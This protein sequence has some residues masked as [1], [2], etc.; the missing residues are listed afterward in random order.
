MENQE[1]K[2]F[3]FFFWFRAGRACA[4]WGQRESLPP[5]LEMGKC[6]IIFETRCGSF[7]ETSSAGMFAVRI[8]N[9]F[10]STGGIRFPMVRRHI[11]SS[12]DPAEGHPGPGRSDNSDFNRKAV[13]AGQRKEGK[14]LRKRDVRK[15]FRDRSAA[16]SMDPA[17]RKGTNRWMKWKNVS[18]VY[19]A[20]N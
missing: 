5:W 9:R 14:V 18:S 13:S 8:K 17:N 1:N 19:A 10:F 6:Q 7:S 4:G 2:Y 11:Y 12:R 15:Y 3:F 16:V 20:K